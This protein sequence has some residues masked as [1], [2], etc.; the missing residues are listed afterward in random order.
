MLFC[1]Q[2]YLFEPLHI[3]KTSNSRNCIVHC[4]HL[5]YLCALLV[6]HHVH[7]CRVLTFCTFLQGVHFF[8]IYAGCACL[9]NF[10]VHFCRVCT[11]S[12][13]F[14]AGC[15]I[16]LLTSFTGCAFLCT[17]AF[18]QG[19]FLCISVG[20]FF[21]AFFLQDVQF[22]CALLQ[23]V[24]F[25]CISSGSCAFFVYF[26]ISAGCAF[27]VH[28]CFSAGSLFFVHFCISAGSEFFV[29]FCSRLCICVHF[30]C[31]V[32]FFCALLL[33]VVLFCA[34]LQQVVLFCALLLQ[35]VPCLCTFAAWCAFWHFYC[36]VVLFRAILQQGVLLC[37]SSAGRAISLFTST[38]G[39]AF[40]VHFCSRLCTSD[41]SWRC[42]PAR[43][44][45]VTSADI[46]ES[47]KK[48]K[49]FL[50]TK[51]SLAAY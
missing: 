36:R 44:G 50:L 42:S 15:A 37:I 40:F 51:K 32:C 5:Q 35:G 27:F 19:V 21:C 34:L 8:C 11:F 14:S 46:I 6:V 13:I 9:C 31:R 22:C 25:L 1:D 24:H 43:P 47:R 4:A 20:V 10:V 7:F 12:C 45:A 2:I 49:T 3:S 26:C 23:G 33:Q 38:A 41:N 16:F 39:F 30:Y 18:L 28:F 48:R 29:H 17:C